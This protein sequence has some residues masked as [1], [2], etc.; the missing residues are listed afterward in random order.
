M[1]MGQNTPKF[2]LPVGAVALDSAPTMSSREIAE[3]V[4]SR[5]DKVKQSIERLVSRGVIAQPPMG[6][7]LEAAANGRTYTTQGCHVGKRDSFVV[8]AQLSPEFTARVVDRWRQP[9]AQMAARPALLSG[10]QSALLRSQI[11]EEIASRRDW[12]AT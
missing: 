10:P 11:V 4:E 6:D 7:V 2:N 1:N 3:L 9:E 12:A 8:V 5:H